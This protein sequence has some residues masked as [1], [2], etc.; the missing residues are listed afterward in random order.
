MI[1]LLEKTLES[2]LDCKV[3][4]PVHSKG[5]QPWIFIGG[6]DVEAE[7]PIR[8][9]PDVKNWL[10]WKDPDAGKDWGRE[11]K[12]TTEDEMAGWHHRLDG[13]DL[14]ELRELVMDREAWRAA[15]HGVA[16]SRTQLSDWSEPNAAFSCTCVPFMYLLWWSIHSYSQLLPSFFGWVVLLLLSCKSYS[17]I[18]NISPLYVSCKYFCLAFWLIFSI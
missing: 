17:C 1:V 8:W 12:G 2:P 16:K 13:H 14:G 7:T 15:I 4:Q 3:I 6:T 9:P 11:K 18:L 5:D 10:I